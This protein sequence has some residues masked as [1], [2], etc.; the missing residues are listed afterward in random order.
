MIALS[1][2][3]VCQP[4]LKESRN[5]KTCHSSRLTDFNFYVLLIY[6][7][8]HHITP[9]NFDKYHFVSFLC[10]KKMSDGHGAPTIYWIV[11]LTSNQHGTELSSI[12]RNNDNQ[13][14]PLNRSSSHDE[15]NT[16]R[17]RFQK[18]VK[19]FDFLNVEQRGIERVLPEDRTDSKIIN[20]A[21]IWVIYIAFLS[22]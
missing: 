22:V 2:F 19:K 9:S 14:I 11:P 7:Y 1:N 4:Y 21:M 8:S 12:C 10:N 13:T 16:V 3:D 15:S 20:T 6:C 17:S 5:E 18:I